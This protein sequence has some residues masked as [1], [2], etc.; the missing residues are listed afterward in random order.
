MRYVD[1]GEVPA[2]LGDQLER[3]QATVNAETSAREE[4]ERFGRTDAF[5]ELGQVLR[6]RFR[7]KC[8]YC[9]A[10]RSLTI[11][12]FWP[13]SP[14]PHNG[15]RGTALRMYR[16]DNLLPACLDCQGFECKGAH[17]SWDGAGNPLLLNP[18]DPHDDPIGFLHLVM[19]AGN[20]AEPREPSLPDG[21]FEPREGL[22]AAAAKRAAN[23]IRRLKLNTG[24]RGADLWEERARALSNLR[25]MIEALRVLGPDHQSPDGRTLRALFAEAISDRAPYL[26][27]IRQLL[28][29]QV[30][31][32]AL[33]TEL[34]TAMPELDPLIRALAPV[35]GTA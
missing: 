10:A 26:A 21:W 17:M 33:R 32:T 3:L 14:H 19:P 12:H 22:D 24:R 6:D 13:K 29:V 16:W 25:L 23:T 31:S 15:Q 4:W 18:C 35:S 7:N 30:D 34:I 28:Y 27:G 8:A 5:R 1:R 20:P 9:E 11:D 2:A